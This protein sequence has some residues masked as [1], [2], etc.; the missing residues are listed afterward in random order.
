MRLDDGRVGALLR[1]DLWRPTSWSAGWRRTLLL[2]LVAVA[3][4]VAYWMLA[5]PHYHP[6]S[7]ADQYFQLASNLAHGKGLAMY[8]PALT[9]H[10]SAFRPPVYPLLLGF[11]YFVFG[12]SVGAGQALSLLTGVGT[13]L[14]TERLANRVAGPVAGLV[15]GLAVAVCVPLVADDVM[16]LSESLS[17]LL[18]AASL[19]LLVERRP[20]LAGVTSGLLILTRPSA[21]GLAVVAALWLW[22]TIGWRRAL[23]FLGVVVLVFSAWVVRN[24]IQLG[25]PVTLTS[26]GYNLAA[27][28]SVPAQQNGGFVNP[29]YD[30]RFAD[31]RLVQFDEVKWSQTLTNRGIAGIE[32]DP[33]YAFNVVGRNSESWFEL[34]PTSGDSAEVLDGRNITVT[35]WALPEFYVFTIGGIA[36]LVVT[37]K[38]RSTVLLIAVSLYFTAASLLLL[39]PPRVRAPFDLINCV[40]L[41]LLAAWWWKRH[42]QMGEVSGDETSDEEAAHPESGEAASQVP[43]T[44]GRPSP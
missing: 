43:M 17:M 18:L 34:V 5:I 26:N 41:G 33:L 27:M 11:W 22:W 9:V 7:D 15:A 16:L 3:A 25:S 42:H 39:A 40:G 44:S 28:Y 6:I 20:V 30:R 8:F 32:H 1:S 14:V 29:I 10:P 23:Y 2:V 31:L 21:Q 24:E 4:R 38:K 35:H 37:R 36:G 19:L 13:V 12:T